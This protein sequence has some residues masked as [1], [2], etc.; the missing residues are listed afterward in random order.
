MATLRSIAARLWGWIT[1]VDVAP[2]VRFCRRASIWLARTGIS[3]YQIKIRYGL[4]IQV[5]EL[6]GYFAELVR[7]NN[8]I[9]LSRIGVQVYQLL[10]IFVIAAA[11]YGQTIIIRRRDERESVLPIAVRDRAVFLLCR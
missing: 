3:K 2:F 11:K 6:S 5:N 1:A 4:A 8:D 9:Q 7:L 10:I